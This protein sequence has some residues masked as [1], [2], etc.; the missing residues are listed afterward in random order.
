MIYT[1]TI[2][3]GAA[4]LLWTSGTDQYT[5]TGESQEGTKTCTLA[6]G[7]NYL[8][9]KGENFTGRLDVT[10]GDPED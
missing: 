1:L 8:V 7:D 6:A 2:E 5:I 10:A 4:E 9:L 3:S